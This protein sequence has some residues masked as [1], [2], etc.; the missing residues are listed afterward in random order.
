MTQVGSISDNN[1]EDE[2]ETHVVFVS[3][4]FQATDR[5]NINADFTFTDATAEM[6]TPIFGPPPA[7]ISYS[8]NQSVPAFLNYYPD[9]TGFDD[10]SDLD[11]QIIDTSIGIDFEIYKNIT[12]SANFRYIDFEDDEPYVYGDQ[13]GELFILNTGITYRF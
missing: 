5:L 11:Y 1:V 6:D 8:V 7:G 9:F 4:N 3:A 12:L 2:L 13:D 10:L